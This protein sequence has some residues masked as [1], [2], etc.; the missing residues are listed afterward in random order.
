MTALDIDIFNT[1]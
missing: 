1:F